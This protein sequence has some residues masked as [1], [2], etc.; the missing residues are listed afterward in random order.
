MHAFGL[1]P[2][3]VDTEMLRFTDAAARLVA[4]TLDAMF[5]NA[6][7]PADSVRAAALR[8]AHLMALRGAVVDRLRRD[9]P[10]FR[11]TT[12]PEHTYPGQTTRVYTVGVDTL[13]V[14]RSD[15][16]EGFVYELT[17]RFFEVLPVLA[18]SQESL[19]LMDL[20]QAPA[21]PIPLHKGAARFYRERELRR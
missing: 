11:L 14:C 17:R 12:I 9:H 4:G 21:T 13:L 8:G 15:L 19:R 2:S 7:Y 5:V 6:S 3:S 18:A 20:E 10:F 16:P 1:E